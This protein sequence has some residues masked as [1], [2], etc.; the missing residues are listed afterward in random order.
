MKDI[1]SNTASRSWFCIWN[2]PQN[3][4]GMEHLS[5]EE[6]VEKAIAM[7]TDGKP[8]RSCA[9]N[10]ELADSEKKTPHLHM[11]LEDP[12]FFRGENRREKTFPQGKKETGLHSGLF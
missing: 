7:W 8:A 6:I 3:R 11:V 1:K 12:A 10:Y 9:I 2:N 4:A 5:P